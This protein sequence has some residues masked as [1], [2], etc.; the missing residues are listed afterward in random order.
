MADLLITN[1]ANINAANENGISVLQRI[2]RF[3]EFQTIFICHVK[4]IMAGTQKFI[5]I[6]ILN[7]FR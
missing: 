3:G 1:G 5:L 6:Y 7:V 4:I 2:I